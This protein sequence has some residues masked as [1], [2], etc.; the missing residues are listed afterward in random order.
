MLANH[1]SPYSGSW[2]PEN[3]VELER[4]L[5]ERFTQ[6]CGRTGPYLLPDA[7]GFVT[8][9]AGPA[10]S[11]TVAAAVYRTLQQLQPETIVV[12]G[13]PHHGGLGGVAI[14][15]VDSISTP[16]GDVRIDPAIDV[17]FTR[18]R[19]VS[20]AQVCD[21]SFEIQ[22][23]FLQKAA[24]RARLL[25]LYVGHMET[26]ERRAVASTLA[27]AWQPGMVFLASSDFT[28]YGRS[29]GYTPFPADSAVA[30]RLRSL[31]F[32]CIDAAGSL[33]ASLFL[34]T[35]REHGATVCGR[36]PIALLLEVLRTLGNDRVYQSVLDYQT[37]G[38]IENNFHHSVS[39]AALAYSRREAFELNLDDREALLDI[40]AETLRRLRQSGNRDVAPAPAASP[41]LEARRG[42]FVSLHHGAELLG[43]IGNCSHREPLAVEAGELVLAAALEDTRF[44]PAADLPGPIDIEISVLTPFRRVR[45]PEQF[46]LGRHGAA[47]KQGTHMGLL[48]PQVAGEHG[49]T[50]EKFL[51]AL[52]HKIHLPSRAWRDPKARLSVFEAQVFSRPGL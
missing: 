32:E 2:Y 8:P 27:D 7:L 44:R 17:R 19:R 1:V 4:L 30:G 20:E 21:H 23:P 6:S 16:L 9:H 14:P 15:D 50:T 10:Y 26:E 35:L 37:S 38:E 25:P 43:C 48:L 42:M 24:P 5:D 13:F 28:H 33:D 29:F 49:W 34:E 12:L 31:D 22:L 3:A 46:S 11:G 41:A 39:Y 45:G 36:D 51:D 47:L 40:A 52:A 18:F